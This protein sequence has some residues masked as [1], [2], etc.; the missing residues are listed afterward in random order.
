MCANGEDQSKR[1]GGNIMDPGTAWKLQSLLTVAEMRSLCEHF[2]PR[3]P[4]LSLPDFLKLA[5]PGEGRRQFLVDSLARPTAPESSRILTRWEVEELLLRP[6]PATAPLAVAVSGNPQ[7]LREPCVA[8]IGSRHPTLYGRMQCARFARELAAAGVTVLSGGAIG[9]DS[10]ATATA[11]ETGRVAVVLGN[12]L[13]HT[14]PRSNH[15]LFRDLA[16][17]PRGLLVSEFPHDAPPTRW[18][19]PR[20]NH[21]IAW[22]A[23]FVLVVEGS[24]ESGSLI[25]ANAALDVNCDV[26]AVPGPVDSPLS[27]GTNLLIRNGAFCIRSPQDVL[28]H[29]ASLVRVR[30]RAAPERSCS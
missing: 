18:S 1:E 11:F 21:T 5:V 24:R 16:E 13:G 29:L 7:I 19:F 4:A 28:D 10:V 26:G 14:H 6:A 15:R 3:V 17:S 30:R 9:I 2:R 27:E 23:D 20:R 22:L 12:G 25:T 8:L